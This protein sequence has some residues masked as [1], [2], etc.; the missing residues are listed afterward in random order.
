MFSGGRGRLH[1]NGDVSQLPKSTCWFRRD[2]Q[3]INTFANHYRF[4]LPYSGRLLDFTRGLHHGS[5]LDEK[6]VRDLDHNA[7]Y[8]EGYHL[9]LIWCLNIHGA[10]QITT[11]DDQKC[12]FPDNI[13][14]RDTIVRVFDAMSPPPPF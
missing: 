11:T 6:M 10:V 14:T 5:V 13:V 8:H 1:S 3:N 2:Q 4:R 9:V 7:N 12:S